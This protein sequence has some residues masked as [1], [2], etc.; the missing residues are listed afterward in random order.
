MRTRDQPASEA[1]DRK[2]RKRPQTAR[3]VSGFQAK[4]LSRPESAAT[5][6]FH[7]RLCDEFLALG[8]CW[9]LAAARKLPWLGETITATVGRTARQ[10]TAP[11]P[12]SPPAVLVPLQS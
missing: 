5:E 8:G 7:I 4:G 3:S 9:S 2:Q 6:S 1:N 11:Q 12:S 10:A